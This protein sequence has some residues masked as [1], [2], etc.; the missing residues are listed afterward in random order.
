MKG[1]CGGIG[2][3]LILFYAACAE[4]LMDT[5]GMKTTIIVSLVVLVVSFIL[6]EIS[7]IPRQ[8]D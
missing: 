8:K 3:A 5:Y 2:F 6:I 4:G 1:I 7:N